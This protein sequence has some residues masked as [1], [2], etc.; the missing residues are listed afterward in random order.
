M[1]CPGGLHMFDR[2]QHVDPSHVGGA[3]FVCR[4]ADGRLYEVIGGASQGLD[5]HGALVRYT[6]SA[7]PKGEARVQTTRCLGL[8]FRF[9]GAEDQH[10]DPLGRDPLLYWWTAL[11]RFALEQAVDDLDRGVFAE[12]K[13]VLSA[14]KRATLAAYSYRVCDLQ[15]RDARGELTCKGA[16]GTDA[17]T[18]LADCEKRAVPDRWSLCEH[19][20]RAQTR[21]MTADQGWIGR[22]LLPALCQIGKQPSKGVPLACRGGPEEL[23]CFKPRLIAGPAPATTAGD[24]EVKGLLSALNVEWHRAYGFTLFDLV[25]YDVLDSLDGDCAD[26]ADYHSRVLGLAELMAKINELAMRE[27]LPEHK[28]SQIPAGHTL[29]VLEAFVQEKG[30]PRGDEAVAALRRVQ[31]LRNLPPTHPADAGGSRAIEELRGLR[32]PYPVPMGEWPRLWQTTRS[33]FA[34]ALALLRDDLQTIHPGRL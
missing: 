11:R 33:I 9:V 20:T 16:A 2:L 29:S 14:D 10:D 3:H 18:P 31:H 5:G 6:V 17:T 26:R 19:V 24:S 27:R 22:R 13:Q 4:A 23:P 1:C 32:F 34:R 21:G 12:G 25:S 8:G 15:E 30:H 28:C 7:Y